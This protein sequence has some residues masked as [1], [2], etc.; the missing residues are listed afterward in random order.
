M[1]TQNTH[2]LGLT[3]ERLQEL[4]GG[5]TPAEVTGHLTA[6][7]IKP[8]LG[9]RGRPFLL[10]TEYLQHPTQTIS[11]DQQTIDID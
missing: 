7:G 4:T 6:N 8:L 9:K 3:Y 2:T 11:P 1:K 5:K 10:P